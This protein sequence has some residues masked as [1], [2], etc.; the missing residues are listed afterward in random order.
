MCVFAYSFPCL[1]EL[2]IP[3]TSH[4]NQK[5]K[6]RNCP[7]LSPLIH[8]SNPF[9]IQLLE[10]SLLLPPTPNSNLIPWTCISGI[11]SFFITTVAKNIVSFGYSDLIISNPFIQLPTWSSLN[12]ITLSTSLMFSSICFLSE[13]A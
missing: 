2:S 10:L 7:I 12:P 11:L 9:N 3:L 1:G 8:I 5:I 13:K 4:E 6:C